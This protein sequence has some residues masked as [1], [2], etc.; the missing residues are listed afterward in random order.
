MLKNTTAMSPSLRR[1]ISKEANRFRPV[2]DIKEILVVQPR[3]NKWTRSIDIFYWCYHVVKREM[4]EERRVF[5][6]T[7]VFF[8]LRFYTV[9]VVSLYVL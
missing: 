6:K 3:T 8:M 9:R 2:Y 1:S 4:R 7:T 5:S